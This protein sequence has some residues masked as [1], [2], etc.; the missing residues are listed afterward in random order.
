[1]DFWHHHFHRGLE[2]MGQ[3]QYRGFGWLIAK[4]LCCGFGI[5]IMS[6]YQGRKRTYST[7]DVSRSVTATIL[8]ATLLAL[9]IH[10]VFALFEYEGIVPGSR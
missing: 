1:P 6:Y 7:T 3:F 10:F 5:A 2:Q 9:S 8:W 4:P